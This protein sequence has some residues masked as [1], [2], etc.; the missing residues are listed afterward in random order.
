MP[1]KH[2]VC[3]SKYFRAAD[4]PAD[5]TLTGEIETARLETVGNGNDTKQK[6]VVYFRRQKPGLV[7][8]PTLWDQFIELTGEEDSNDWPGHMAELF[9]TTTQFGGKTVPCIRV[10][11]PDAPKKPKKAPSKPLAVDDD[12]NDEIA[13]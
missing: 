9:V 13:F 7:C 4:Y 5:W 12:M 10:R 11:K 3:T 1:K 2:E 6:L 8:G